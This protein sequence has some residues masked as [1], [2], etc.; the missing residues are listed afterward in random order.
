MEQRDQIWAQAVA[1]H[2]AGEQHWL[3]EEEE[4]LLRDAQQPH[5]ASDAWEENVLSYVKGQKS[6]SAKE[7]LVQCLD[8]EM[9]DI[10]QRE[11][12]RI[13]FILRKNGWMNYRSTGCM[14]W[15]A[16]DQLSIR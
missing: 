10:G 8:F 6:V 13:A 3:T 16:P 4:N 9:K 7:V 12:N 1:L 15:R 11:T 14:R 5:T 2:H